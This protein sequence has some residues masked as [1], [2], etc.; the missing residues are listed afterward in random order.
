MRWA[1][2][3]SRA[4]ITGAAGCEGSELPSRSLHRREHKQDLRVYQSCSQTTTT[5]LSIE[6]KQYDGIMGGYFPPQLIELGLSIMAAPNGETCRSMSAAAAT[7]EPASH[8]CSDSIHSPMCQRATH[9]GIKTNRSG[10]ERHDR[11]GKMMGEGSVS[12]IWVWSRVRSRSG[13][14]K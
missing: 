9:R 2:C 3:C 6:Q 14:K 12:E 5:N 4:I 1:P 7:A 8:C 11:K 13:W 10:G